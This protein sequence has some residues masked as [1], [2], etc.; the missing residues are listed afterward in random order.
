MIADHD[1]LTTRRVRL[2][3]LCLP[4]ALMACS[5]PPSAPPAA[6]VAAAKVAS[7][8]SEASLTSITLTAEAVARL[9]IVTAAVEQ[10]G[11]TRSRTLGGDVM[12]TAGAQSTVTAPVAGTLE[13]GD[14]PAAI[15]TTVRKGATIVRLVP[16]A[17]AER[18]VRIEAERAVNE[19]TGRQTLA[20]Q[21]VD[22]ATRLAADGSGSRRAAEEAQADL[23]VANA[24]LEASQDRLALASRGVSGTGALAL[25]APAEAL[26]VAVYAG[27]GQTVAAGAPLFDLVQL[28]TVW[29]RVPLYAGDVAQIDRRG[30]ARIVPVGAAGTTP[31]TVARPVTAPPSADPSTAAID[32]YYAV[33]NPGGALRPGQRVG[34]RVPLTSEAQSLVV[35]HAALLH[36]ASG[37]SWVYEARGSNVFVRRRVS[38]VDLVDGFAV[39]DHGP[40][41]GTRVVTAGAAELFG[42]EFGAGK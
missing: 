28:D 16:L 36:D 41:P 3:L 42:A 33:S 25:N 1:A 34:V 31:G 10:R 19:A 13:A 7:P 11:V 18:D 35:P 24:A 20:A 26:L 4:V 2:S 21:R 37:G 6:S 39:L 38:V 23:V 30:A 5:G 14:G 32:L 40:A 15:G 9:G 17:P 29:I 8:V 27:A 22:R 12:P